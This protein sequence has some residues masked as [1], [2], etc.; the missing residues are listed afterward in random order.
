MIEC[1][2]DHN[3]KKLCTDTNDIGRRINMAV[4]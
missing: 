1:I 2:Y 4:W 3:N